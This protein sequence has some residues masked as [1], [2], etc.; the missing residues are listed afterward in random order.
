MRGV[1]AQQR[2]GAIRLGRALRGR[3]LGLL[4]LLTVPEKEMGLDG[5][6]YVSDEVG[7]WWFICAVKWLGWEG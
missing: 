4:L 1:M 7:G 5:L 2:R 3:E 6:H